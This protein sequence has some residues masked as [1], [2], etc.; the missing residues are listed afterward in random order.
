[1]D[2]T[3]SY[4]CNGHRAPNLEQVIKIA[5]LFNVS[6]DYLTGVTDVSSTDVDIKAMRNYLGLYEETLHDLKLLYNLEFIPQDY[7]NDFITSVS[8]NLD[9][10]QAFVIYRN[11]LLNKL[12]YRKKQ[13]ETLVKIDT[14][15]TIKFFSLYDEAF[16]DDLKDKL[17]LQRFRLSHYI[18]EACNCSSIETISETLKYE[19]KIAELFDKETSGEEKDQEIK[20]KFQAI[21]QQFADNPKIDMLFDYDNFF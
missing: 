1:T 10:L 17:D 18:L 4:W 21:H 14:E 11:L 9:L 2:N 15:S 8:R 13:Y 16:F 19:N 3:V 7:F 6:I 12:K 20:E 5:T